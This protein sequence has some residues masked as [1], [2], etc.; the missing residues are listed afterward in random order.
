MKKVVFKNKNRISKQKLGNQNEKLKIKS[1]NWFSKVKVGFVYKNPSLRKHSYINF[2]SMKSKES[3]F[4]N[5]NKRIQQDN[6]LIRLWY[7]ET[8][9]HMEVGFLKINFYFW[10][11]L[12]S[13][14]F[15]F[16]I[17]IFNF[18]IW[19]STFLF[20]FEFQFETLSFS[21]SNNKINPTLFTYSSFSHYTDSQ[22]FAF[23]S[24]ISEKRN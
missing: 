1:K 20:D 19:F 9:D 11:P 23:C 17:L 3:I 6:T 15:Q 12:F 21:V 13:F 14:V 2:K 7:D 24:D 8:L 16:F 10:N 4:C 5:N 22:S 18:L